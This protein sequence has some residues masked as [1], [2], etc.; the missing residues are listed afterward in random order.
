M[1]GFVLLPS[2]VFL[3]CDRSLLIMAALVLWKDLS[4]NFI[5]C[6]PK[7]SFSVP[8][9]ASG[10]QHMVG[11]VVSYVEEKQGQKSSLTLFSWERTFFQS[12]S[13]RGHLHTNFSWTYVLKKLQWLFPMATLGSLCLLSLWPSVLALVWHQ[14]SVSLLQVKL[15]ICF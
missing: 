6:V 12:H 1:S 13:F 15:C 8:T 14:G 5:S 2:P 10:L 3:N 11:Q 9:R 7:T 4:T